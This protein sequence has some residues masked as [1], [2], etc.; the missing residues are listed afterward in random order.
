MK[1]FLLGANRYFWQIL[2]QQSIDWLL[3]DR[4]LRY[5]VFA[6]GGALVFSSS[7]ES[8]SFFAIEK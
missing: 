1:L 5:L 6:S 2:L 8:E 7:A 3:D 4:V